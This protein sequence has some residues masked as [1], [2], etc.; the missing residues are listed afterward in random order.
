MGDGRWAMVRLQ[1]ERVHPNGRICYRGQEVRA[2]GV[3]PGVAAEEMAAVE[4]D[5]A[6]EVPSRRRR[7]GVD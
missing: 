3:P 2:D 6:A 5:A 1:V 4:S 7:G